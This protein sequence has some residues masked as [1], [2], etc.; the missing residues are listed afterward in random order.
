MPAANTT[1]A[2]P[3]P[4]HAPPATGAAHW[5]ATY[6]E[7]DDL[8]WT[9]AQA[10]SGSRLKDRLQALYACH[11]A[12]ALRTGHASEWLTILAERLDRQAA[13]LNARHQAGARHYADLATLARRDAEA[14][15]PSRPG[16]AL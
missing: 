16:Y 1:P 2:L 12:A 8:V 15:R 9:E 11:R 13:A 10:E 3:C 14:L 6:P 4:A 7:W 5:P